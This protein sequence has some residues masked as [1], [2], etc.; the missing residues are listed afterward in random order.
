V[1]K[2][3]KFIDKDGVTLYFLDPDYAAAVCEVDK[4]ILETFRARN[5]AMPFPQLEVQMLENAA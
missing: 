4:A 1:A 3:P 2:Y 5:I